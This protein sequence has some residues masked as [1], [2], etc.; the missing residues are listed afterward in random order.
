MKFFS[1]FPGAPIGIRATVKVKVVCLQFG[2]RASQ[3][4]VVNQKWTIVCRAK[5]E[6]QS[7]YHRFFSFIIPASKSKV[8]IH[9]GE[10]NLSMGFFI[11]CLF[12]S[13]SHSIIILMVQ[14]HSLSGQLDM[15]HSLAFRA[16]FINSLMTLCT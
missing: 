5:K 13:R 14:S 12:E 2:L 3:Q 16:N 6:W 9:R 1:V 10:T 11:S 8:N 4:N 7:N 15:H